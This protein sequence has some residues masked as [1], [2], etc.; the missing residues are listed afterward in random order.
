MMKWKTFVVGYALALALLL[1][2]QH[3]PQQTTS[4]T[5]AHIVDLTHG[6]S[7]SRAAAASSQALLPQPVSATVSYPQRRTTAIHFPTRLQAPAHYAPGLWTVAQIPPQRLFAPLAVIDVHGQARQNADYQLT[8]TDIANWEQ[9]HGQIPLGAVVVVRTGWG[10]RWPSAREYRNRDDHGVSHFPG[11]S[12]QAVRFLV[13]GRKV[14]G[15]GTD[16]ASIDPGNVSDSPASDYALSHSVYQI[17]N[18]ANLA[19]APQTGGLALVAP[20]KL[21]GRSQAPTRVLALAK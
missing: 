20:A 14:V 16:T 10:S 15:L 1:F 2:A 4:A 5:F 8:V 21:Q 7:S 18:L 13:Q 6:I 12:L 17:D 19:Q 11:F 9:A 3:R